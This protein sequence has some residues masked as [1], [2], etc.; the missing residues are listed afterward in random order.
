MRPLKGLEQQNPQMFLL[1]VRFTLATVQAKVRERQEWKTETR[2]VY[3]KSPDEMWWGLDPGR[4]LGGG[5]P[6]CGTN[7]GA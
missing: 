5:E 7:T 4:K 6:T 2:R 3:A 1:S